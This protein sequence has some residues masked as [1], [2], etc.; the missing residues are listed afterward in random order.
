MN[1]LDEKFEGQ[2]EKTSPSPIESLP[3][4]LRVLLRVVKSFAGCPTEECASNY[5]SGT[6]TS[7]KCAASD[8]SRKTTLS[9]VN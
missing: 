9:F 8:C 7:A 5:A 2:T 6:C 1:Q 3:E 4:R